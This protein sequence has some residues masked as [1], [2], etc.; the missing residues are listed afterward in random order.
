[1]SRKKI[2]DD[3]VAVEAMA[4]CVSE[5]QKAE[6]ALD[7]LVQMALGIIFD[8]HDWT[9]PCVERTVARCFWRLSGNYFQ[10]WKDNAAF[11]RNYQE[12]QKQ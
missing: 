6:D 3:T 5:M 2:H 12:E 9:E 7:H 11:Y 8:R 10:E 4:K 1:M